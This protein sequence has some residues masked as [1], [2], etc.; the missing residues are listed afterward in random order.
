MANIRRHCGTKRMN[1]RRYSVLFI[2]TSSSIGIPDSIHCRTIELWN[3]FCFLSHKMIL[4]TISE[5]EQIDERMLN[6]YVWD[7]SRR[8]WYTWLNLQ[9][10]TQLIMSI[11]RVSSLWNIRAN[12]WWKIPLLINT[13][14]TYIHSHDIRLHAYNTCCCWLTLETSRQPESNWN[15]VSHS[16]WM[17]TRPN[18]IVHLNIRVGNQ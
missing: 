10:C 11:A 3:I 18:H 1:D 6:G 9:I 13:Y 5:G 2:W 8:K 15:V 17:M 4:H 14:Y 7:R 16:D 12:Y